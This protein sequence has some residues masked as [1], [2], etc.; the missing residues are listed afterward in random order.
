M[1]KENL[2]KSEVQGRSS[3]KQNVQS[4]QKFASWDLTWALWWSKKCKF[5]HHWKYDP[6]HAQIGHFVQSWILIH[7]GTLIQQLNSP[8]SLDYEIWTRSTHFNVKGIWYLFHMS[9]LLQFASFQQGRKNTISFKSK[10][11]FRFAK[12]MQIF[13]DTAVLPPEHTW[14]TVVEPVV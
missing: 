9:C 2:S 3:P 5:S 1:F 7:R 8:Q 10:N 4:K 14:C 6:M 12:K 13:R 11:G